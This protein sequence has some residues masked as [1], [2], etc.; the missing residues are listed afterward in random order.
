MTTA[1]DRT[2]LEQLVA[3]ATD[4]LVYAP[5]GLFFEGPSLVTKLA[6][7]GRVHANN[8]RLFGQFA[9]RHGEAELRRRV[10]GIEEQA[11][12]WLKL[13]GL[14]PEDEPLPAPTEPAAP[15]APVAAGPADAVQ[16]NG[17][18]PPERVGP[19]V[20]DLAIPDYD[21]LS[22]SQVVTRLE[23][24]SGDELEAV[25]AYEAAHRGRKTIL[26]KVAQLQA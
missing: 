25:R 22:A 15:A 23:G 21:S 18:A 13:F 7:Q 20:G 19:T 4:L 26:N 5:I 12:G 10:E 9:V 3:Q 17:V 1:D 6:Q 11:T 14:V 2:P 8:A 24:L 16:G